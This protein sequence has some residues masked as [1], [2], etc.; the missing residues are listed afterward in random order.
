MSVKYLKT[1]FILSLLVIIGVLACDKK[2][3]VLNLSE[4][5]ELSN[6]QRASVVI[7]K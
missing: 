1:R 3:E 6:S 7:L 2:D 5:Q 4:K